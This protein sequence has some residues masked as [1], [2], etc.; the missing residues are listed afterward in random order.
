VAYRFI[1]FLTRV[2]EE[3]RS[4]EAIVWNDRSFDYA[5]LLERIEHWSRRLDFFGIDPGR[6]VLLEGD[7]SPNSAALF[8]ALIERQA[9]IV[10]LSVAP[11]LNRD[12]FIRV[13][14]VESRIKLDARDEASCEITGQL[15]GHALYDRLR[16]DGHPGLVL[17]SSG[18]T[19]ESKA[20]VHDFD[21]LLG[22]F[23]T[24]RRN[25]RTVAFLLFDHIGGIDTL[26]YSL[27]NGSCVITLSERSPEAVCAAIEHRRAEVL[28]VSPTFLNLLILSEAYRR[29]DLS[30]LQFIT[31]GTEVMPE[32]TLKRCAE[33]FPGVTILQKYGT[34]EV[35]T[36]RSKSESSSST[37]VKI[38]GEGYATRVV[39]GKLQ[40]KADSAM[41]GY[42]NAPSP[43]T[44][45]GWFAT[46][47]QVEQ[48]G[49]YLR[50]LGR[51]SDII[52]VGGEKVFPAEVESVIKELD[53]VAE[54][55]VYG[56]KNPIV[57]NIICA[58]VRLR[59]NADAKDAI[60][61]IKKH[62]R[63]RLPSF[64]VPVKVEAVKDWQ[65]NVRFKKMRK[66]TGQP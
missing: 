15:A 58:R 40:I 48:N 4:A 46:G 36:L 37:W 57:G 52:N 19:G 16:S 64:K 18:S 35:G 34:T 13:G 31:Y 6:V 60:L 30:S 27:S 38:G 45:D 3:N 41:L 42:L 1:E 33:L 39:D 2:F 59:E 20:A 65:Y 17:F 51:E 22:K 66:T 49:E 61:N 62:C 50:F 28:P 47:D 21:K 14:Q 24:R 32:A 53:F 11:D 26:L 7:F 12:K 5:W 10:P 9:I 23:R 8:L 63:S 56:E 43:F 55:E 29:F 54:A 25:L 44:E